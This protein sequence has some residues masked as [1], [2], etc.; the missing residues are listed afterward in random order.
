MK[1]QANL[2]EIPT[3]FA[4]IGFGVINT[5]MRHEMPYYG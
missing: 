1:S 2:M 4:F 3:T 5:L